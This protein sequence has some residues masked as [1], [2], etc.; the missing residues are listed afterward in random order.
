[1]DLQLFLA[2]RVDL[3]FIKGLNNKLV[4]MSQ[5]ISDI[6]QNKVVENREEKRQ[7]DN[8]SER[9][10][11]AFSIILQYKRDWCRLASHQNYWPRC[12][13][14]SFTDQR[15][16]TT[17]T[18]ARDPLP[19]IAHMIKIWSSVLFLFFFKGFFHSNTVITEYYCLS[20]YVKQ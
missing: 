18:A 16:K 11:V 6:S 1:M 4:A 20:I 9:V 15:K 5:Y 10:R 12:Y 13:T 7:T 2:E 3:F 14:L 8:Q 17:A 19:N